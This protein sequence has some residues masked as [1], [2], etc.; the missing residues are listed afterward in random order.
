M[1]ISAH[2]K[3]ATEGMAVLGYIAMAYISGNRMAAIRMRVRLA[4]VI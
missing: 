3:Q 1:R 4:C 2:R